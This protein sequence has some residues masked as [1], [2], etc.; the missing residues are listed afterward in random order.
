MRRRIVNLRGRSTGALGI[1]E[2]IGLSIA[3]RLGK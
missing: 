2:G 1:D 3:D